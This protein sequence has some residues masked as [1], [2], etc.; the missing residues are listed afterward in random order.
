MATNDILGPVRRVIE[1][2]FKTY[3]D[4]NGGGVPVQWDGVAFNQPAD[5]IWVRFTLLPGEG[6]RASLGSKWLE[7]Q[8]GVC[9]V[10][11][12]GPKNGG[13]GGVY[14]IA[15]LVCKAF[16]S[17]QAIDDEVVVTLDTPW[18]RRVEDPDTV[19]LNVTCAYEAHRTMT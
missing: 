3:W 16:R 4:A 2:R 9:M 7:K 10:S 19:M 17:Y 14:G 12:F 5:G 6:F 11:V 18:V 13:T 15:E 1:T 8:P